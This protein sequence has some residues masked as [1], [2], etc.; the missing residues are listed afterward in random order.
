MSTVT[1][2][3]TF[4]GSVHEAESRWYDTGSWSK[5]VDG[6]ARVASVSGDWP[7]RGA[8]VVWESG[9]A[10]RG[11]VTESVAAFEPLGGQTNDVQDD[12]IDAR[13]SVTFTPQDDSV[14]VQ[15]TLEYRIRKRN[16]F[17]PLVD[18]LFIRRAMALS[19]RSTLERFGAELAAARRA[20]SG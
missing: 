2:T 15:L 14:E 18:L 4:P 8:T 3:Q 10:G 11:R 19:L 6:L 12:S 1:V 7:G 9:P 20:G 17:T 5:W 16:L 13:Q